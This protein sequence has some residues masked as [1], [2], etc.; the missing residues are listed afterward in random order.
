MQAMP[1]TTRLQTPLNKNDGCVK[2]CCFLVT[3]YVGG[4][5]TEPH[6]LMDSIRSPGKLLELCQESTWSPSGVHQESPW[7]PSA[8]SYCALPKNPARLLMESIRMETFPGLLIQS[9][10]TRAGLSRW[11][12]LKRSE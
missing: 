9:L 2:C 12:P 7:S 1:K 8:S 3:H 6:I 11:T 4:S 5:Y 10:K